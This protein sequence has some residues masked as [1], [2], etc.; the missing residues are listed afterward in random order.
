MKEK[1]KISGLTRPSR[2]GE[3]YQV[4]ECGAQAQNSEA[5]FLGLAVHLHSSATV[6]CGPCINFYFL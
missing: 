1:G 3:E 5:V 6:T 4:C 2:E